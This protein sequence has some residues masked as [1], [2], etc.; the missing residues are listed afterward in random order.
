[1]QRREFVTLV[2]AAVTWPLAATATIPIVFQTA[3]DPVE[4]GLVASFNRP[5]GNITG[6]SSQNIELAGKRI[7]LLRELLPKR[8]RFALL[9]NPTV[10]LAERTT[11]EAHQAA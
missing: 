6:V 3:G 8:T 1:M 4:D 5:G 9:M 10:P 11:R 7:G 2:G